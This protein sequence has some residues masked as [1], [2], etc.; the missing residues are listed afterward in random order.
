MSFF[1]KK[2]AEFEKNLLT[3]YRLYGLGHVGN[4]CLPI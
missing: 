2:S 3:L 1:G 4:V